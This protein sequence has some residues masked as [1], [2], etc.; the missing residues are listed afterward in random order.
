MVLG[1]TALHLRRLSVTVSKVKLAP[2]LSASIMPKSEL[3]AYQIM[4]VTLLTG[5]LGAHADEVRI[6]EIASESDNACASIAAY[7]QTHAGTQ[8]LPYIKS[9]GANPNKVVCEATI[10]LMKAVDPARIYGLTCIGSH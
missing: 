3:R 5:I 9:C 10:D 1:I 7:A 4:V 8:I 6:P 2:H